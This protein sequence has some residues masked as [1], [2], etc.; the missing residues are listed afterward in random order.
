MNAVEKSI[1]QVLADH[2]NPSYVRPWNL[3]KKYASSGSGFCI[4]WQNK[5]VIL[6]NAH[7]IHNASHI[8]LRK[9]G[10]SHLFKATVIGKLYECDLALLD[11]ESIEFWKDITPLEISGL[12]GKLS[13]V[14]VYGYPLGGYNI[15][16]TKGV[17]NR[18][19]IVTYFH[20]VEGIAIQIDAAINPGNSGGPAIDANGKVVGVAFAGEAGSDLQ[21]MGYIIPTTLVRYFLTVMSAKKPFEGLCALPIQ[22]QPINNSAMVQY[23]SL[24]PNDKGVLIT[25]HTEHVGH[26]GIGLLKMGDVLQGINNRLIEND[27]TMSLLDVIQECDKDTITMGDT[28]LSLANGEIVPFTSMISLIPAG[29][30][31]SLNILRQGKK[32][33]IPVVTRHID[34][35]IP[36][37]EY[38]MAPSYMIIGG[39][40]FIPVSYMSLIEKKKMGEDVSYSVDLPKGKAKES[41]QLIM[42]SEIFNNDMTEGY[43]AD[44]IIVKSLNGH[45]IINL[46]QFHRLV[47]TELKKSKFLVF[48]FANSLQIIVLNSNQVVK[49]HKRILLDNIGHDKDLLDP[50]VEGG[51]AEEPESDT[52]GDCPNA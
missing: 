6:T 27:G 11:V 17:V 9:R 15:S 36:I 7:C 24:Q 26:T 21:N 43:A 25:G 41:S 20:V 49:N 45:P 42:L 51:D 3:K 2:I 29:V 52:N 13:K 1:V 37:M 28:S 23:L 5:K 48:Q 33:V 10:T 38:Q 40:V 31:I 16:V 14:Y 35:T 18:I 46:S 32:I 8:N 50:S 34:I 39:L 22:Y 19:H 30:T 44:N 4:M 12:P 47:K